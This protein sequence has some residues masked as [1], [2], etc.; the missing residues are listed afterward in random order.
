MKSLKQ[1]CNA[2]VAMAL[3]FILQIYKRDSRIKGRVY[4]SILCVR[5]VS[6]LGEGFCVLLPVTVSVVHSSV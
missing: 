5:C 2:E 6:S 1:D 4:I 3:M